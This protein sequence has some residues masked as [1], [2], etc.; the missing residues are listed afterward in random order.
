MQFSRYAPERTVSTVRKFELRAE[1]SG[2]SP[3]RWLARG[4]VLQPREAQPEARRK[5]LLQS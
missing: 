4:A 3:L 1:G 5:A 2:G